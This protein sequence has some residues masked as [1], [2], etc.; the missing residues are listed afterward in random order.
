MFSSFLENAV[1]AT[2]SLGMMIFSSYQGNTPSFVECG[3]THRG[4]R[5]TIQATLENAFND[6][7]RQ[8][9]QSGEEIVIAFHLELRSEMITEILDFK[10]RVIFDPLM[11]TWS[12]TCE[13]KNRTYT[14][15]SWSEF[16]NAT[17]DF[18]YSGDHY[19]ETPI[20]V[21]LE[22]SLPKIN[23]GQNNREFNLLLLWNYH[24]PAYHHIIR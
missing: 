22:A 15:E 21:F 12:L 4:N 10:H 14:I 11:E 2:I 9:L 17:S 19:L 6:D 1:T 16:T 24:K 13:E 18:N 3:A 20:E 7:F 5:I 23:L 8:I